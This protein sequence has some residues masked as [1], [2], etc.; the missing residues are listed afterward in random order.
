MESFIT[1]LETAMIMEVVYTGLAV[2]SSIIFIIQAVLL[3][4]G[5]DTDSDFSGGD[6]A[7]DVDGMN[8]VSWKTISCFLLGFGWTGVIFDPVFEN[9]T[10]VAIMAVAVGVIFMF[11]IAFLMRMVMRLSY[12]GTFTTGKVVGS[13]GAVYLR[14]PD[15]E[16]PGKVTVSYQGSMHELTAYSNERLEMGTHVTIVRAIDSS[17]I[18][19]ERC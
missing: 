13:I 4:I 17:T 6:A 16:N 14:I 7:F 19:V 18:F 1:F 12:D 11:L 9:K 2:F 3:F 8:L 15:A 5:F 10:V